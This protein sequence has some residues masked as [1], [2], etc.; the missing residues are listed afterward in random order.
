[1]ELTQCINY[2]LTIAQHSVFQFLSNQLSEYDITPSQYGVLSCLWAKEY[3]TP[4]QISEIL[5]LETSTISGVLDRMQKKGLIERFVNKE[6]RREVRIVATEKGIALQ[7]PVQDIIERVNEVVLSNFS[8]YDIAVLK[9][10][11]KSIASTKYMMCNYVV[12]FTAFFIILS[13]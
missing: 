11:L 7:Q 2:L 3:A 1:M 8:E 4:K 6:D 13:M 9:Q 12:F 10:N 5:C